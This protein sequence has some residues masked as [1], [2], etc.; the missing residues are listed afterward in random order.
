MVRVALFGVLLLA[1][2][3]EK[4]IVPE[5]PAAPV[6]PHGFRAPTLRCQ[7]E[8]PAAWKIS[9][10][11]MP[12]HVLEMIANAPNLRGRMVI[13]EAVEQAVDDAVAAQKERT[14]AA[15]G[16]QADFALL[17]EEPLGQGKLVVYR[18]RRQGSAPMDRHLIAA[19]P[20]ESRVVLAFIDDDGT[21]PESH[22]L[23]SL[24]TLR[25]RTRQ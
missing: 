6:I 17:R 21:T 24:G 10:S 15:W 9:N 19:L 4:E 14:Q 5:A 1:G 11:P 23:G 12:D 20:I 18:W 22:L 13:R 16:T 2:C 8:V 3:P 7:L 25:C